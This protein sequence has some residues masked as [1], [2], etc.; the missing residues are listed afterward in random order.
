MK[1]QKRFK[2]QDEI[3]TEIDRVKWFYN[4]KV[5]EAERLSDLADEQFENSAKAKNPA[6]AGLLIK[7]AQFNRSK[8]KNL[9]KAATRID[10]RLEKL[11]H[12]HSAFLTSTMPFLPDPSVVLQ[13]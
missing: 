2:S 8:S 9:F 7:E 10:G 12:T 5:K 3:E 4:E 1:K 13:K 6:D 11:K